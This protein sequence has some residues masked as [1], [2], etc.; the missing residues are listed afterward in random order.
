[1]FA[2]GD[3]ILPQLWKEISDAIEQTNGV[4]IEE[5]TKGNVL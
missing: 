5:T 1:M 4:K 3:S 2:T